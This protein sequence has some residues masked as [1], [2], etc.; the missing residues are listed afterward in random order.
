M[1]TNAFIHRVWTHSQ[2]TRA[3][4]LAPGVTTDIEAQT[5]RVP[6]HSSR[7]PTRMRGPNSH[8]E[9]THRVLALHRRHEVAGDSDVVCSC[10]RARPRSQFLRSHFDET[11]MP[12]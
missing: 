2:Q 7:L 11:Q 6:P 8:G 10:P 3:D 4:C 12:A 1:T 5:I 9:P